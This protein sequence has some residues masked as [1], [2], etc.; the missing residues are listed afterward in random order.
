MTY[1]LSLKH[2]FI[3]FGTWNY[4]FNQG[5]RKLDMLDT[6]MLALQMTWLLSHKANEGKKTS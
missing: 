4:I 3:K 2:A 5:E 6:Y 1:V